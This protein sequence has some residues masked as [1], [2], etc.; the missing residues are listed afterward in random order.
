MKFSPSFQTDFVTREQQRDGRSVEAEKC[1]HAA[2]TGNLVLRH[3]VISSTPGGP[4]G[5]S[6]GTN[7]GTRAESWGKLPGVA[8]AGGMLVL[9][10][11]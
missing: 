2:L 3:Y 9:G 7:P 5:N 1:L 4:P 11:D 8:G 10:I 6:D